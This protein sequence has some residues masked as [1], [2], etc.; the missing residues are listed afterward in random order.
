MSRHINVYALKIADFWNGVANRF[1]T[2]SQIIQR[3]KEWSTGIAALLVQYPKRLALL[4]GGAFG[5]VLGVA[6]LPNWS[7]KKQQKDYITGLPAV[8]VKDTGLAEVVRLAEAF[9]STLNEGQVAQLQLAYSKSS[10]VRWSNFPQAFSRPNRVGLA[11]GSLN[12]TQTSAFKS[13]M[14]FV[15]SRTTANEGYDELEGIRLADD[16]I[17]KATGKADA[18][19]AG[20]YYIAFLGQPGT[21]SL[22]E[23]QYGGHHYAFANTY[24]NGR[25]AGVTPT[26]RGTEPMTPVNANGRTYEP[27]E[28]ERAAFAKLLEGLSD[29]EKNT[30]RLSKSFS[31]VLL[32]PGKDGM[33]PATKQGIRIGDLNS[34]RQKQVLQAIALYVNDLEA[35]TAKPIM[36]NY[37]AELKDTYL[38]YAGSGAMNQVND[39]LRIDGPGIWLEY[40][41]QPSRD[42]PGPPH[43]H[44]VWRDHR[45]D[46]GDN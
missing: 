30:A 28:Q 18:F 32:G 36:K 34:S 46:Y 44:S 29:A 33:F 9:K 26:F 27:M 23:L 19:G 22:W 38:A 17:A 4:C 24:N 7:N 21:S 25:L 11:L 41:S 13:L 8:F 1:R 20:N 37:T 2:S 14:S 3:A 31:D 39:Y 12:A 10:A 40:S 5:V 15:L 42:I 6:L 35:A 16:A 45:S 43:A